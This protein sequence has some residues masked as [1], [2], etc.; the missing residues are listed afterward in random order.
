MQE[1]TSRQDQIA[2]L[3]RAAMDADPGHNGGGFTQ[4]RKQR[5]KIRQEIAA[6]TAAK[7]AG[8]FGPVGREGN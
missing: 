8:L 1:L 7:I 4:T 2:A 6:K 5:E 3:V